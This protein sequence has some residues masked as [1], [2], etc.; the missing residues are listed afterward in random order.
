MNY[1]KTLKLRFRV[2]DAN[3]PERRKRYTSSREEEEVAPMCPCGKAVK[4]RTHI[5][6][7]CE[8]CK[9][10]LDVFEMSEINEYDV[11]KFGTLKYIVARKRS[12][13]LGDCLLYTSD[14]ADE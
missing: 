2:G 3:L 14:A 7:E 13:I 9:E 6:R 4:S 11:K 5:V 10:E 1:P 8:M 12:L